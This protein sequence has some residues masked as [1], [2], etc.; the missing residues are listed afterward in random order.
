MLAYLLNDKNNKNVNAKE[1]HMHIHKRFT[2]PV[3][4]T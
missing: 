4:V 3:C 1:V 2:N